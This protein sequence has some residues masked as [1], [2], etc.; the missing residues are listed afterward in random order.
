M[1]V[2]TIIVTS[3]ERKAVTSAPSRKMPINSPRP[4]VPNRCAIICASISNTPAAS[5]T[6]VTI[7]MPNRKSNTLPVS[8]STPPT[9][10]G[11]ARRKRSVSAAPTAAPYASFSSRGRVSTRA[12]VT[13][14]TATLRIKFIAT[15][16]KMPRKIGRL[17]HKGTETQRKKQ[18]ELLFLSVSPCLCSYVPLS[19]AVLPRPRTTASWFLWRY[20]LDNGCREC[21]G[22]LRRGRRLCA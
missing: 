10:P 4:L 22:R 5:T 17:N 14:S 2:S 13:T 8:L 19:F 16:P 15:R 3:S 1:G 6:P 20:R 21:G 11:V 7:I 9:S 12:S 18:K